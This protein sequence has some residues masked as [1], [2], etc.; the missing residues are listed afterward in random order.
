MADSYLH[1]IENSTNANNEIFNVGDENHSV[2][3]LAE[4]VN[5]SC[6]E[7]ELI[8]EE[9]FDQ[10]SYKISS[11]KIYKKLG[12]KTK[13]TIQNAI[14]D[15]VEAF[16]QKKLINTFNDDNFYNIKIIKNK[17]NSLIND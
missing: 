6:P 4:M 8:K 9:V 2:N 13:K 14:D 1:V 3:K 17:L 16:A 7:A 12:F 11:E 15:L 5:K 10:R